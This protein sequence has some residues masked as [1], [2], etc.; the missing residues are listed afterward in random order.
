VHP[1]CARRPDVHSRAAVRRVDPQAVEPA[2]LQGA[3]QPTRDA[4]SCRSLLRQEVPDHR[5]G[6]VVHTYVSVASEAIYHPLLEND[7]AVVIRFDVVQTNDSY[8]TIYHPLLRQQQTNRDICC[9]K[10]VVSTTKT[11][12][13]A[14]FFYL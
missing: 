11:K 3:R 4:A 5:A 6:S 7:I 8:T 13:E 14:N 10:V 9:F 2:Q 1:A 12:N